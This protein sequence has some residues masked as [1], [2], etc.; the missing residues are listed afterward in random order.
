MI[1]NHARFLLP[2]STAVELPLYLVDYVCE[3][4]SLI[5]V[6]P[7]FLSLLL[8]ALSWRYFF[9]IL[10]PIL[11]VYRP[12]LRRIFTV[13]ISLLVGYLCQL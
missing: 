6:A 13:D 2:L 11:L 1:L 9:N 5:D 10:G 7:Y 12:F 4:T 8:V 3:L